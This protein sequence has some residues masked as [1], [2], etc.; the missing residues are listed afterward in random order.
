LGLKLWK[1][2]ALLL[3]RG[4]PALGTTEAVCGVRC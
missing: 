3:G 1:A 2:G 4:R